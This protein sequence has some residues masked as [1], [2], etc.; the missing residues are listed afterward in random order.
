MNQDHV[1]AI[2]IDTESSP[3]AFTVVFSGKSNDKVNGLYKPDKAEILLHNQNFE[4]DDQLI[5]T[6]LHEYA[7]HLHHC[8]RGGLS[9]SR[10]HTNE[11]WSIFHELLLKAEA[12]GHYHNVYD[13]EPAFIELTARIR[14]QCIRANGEVML[15]FGRLLAQ[16]SELCRTHKTRFEDYVDRVLGV[17]RQTAGAA[18]AASGFGIDPG[19]GWDGMKMAVGIRDPELRA[20]AVDALKSGSSPAAVKGMFAAQDAIEDPA[21]RLLAEKERIERSMASMRS[22]LDEIIRRLAAMGEPLDNDN[23]F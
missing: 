10:S 13:S 2:L 4:S 8:R 6:A 18:V 20:K 21:E 19:I 1:L 12:K 17:P 14:E 7:H 5:Y 16:A 9:Q 11:F 15:E 23:P 22:R 3:A